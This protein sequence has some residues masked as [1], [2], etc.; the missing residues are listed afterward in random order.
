MNETSYCFTPLPAFG[1]VSVPNFGHSNRYVV[2]SHCCFSSNFPADTTGRFFHI[3]ICYLYI[4]FGWT[5]AEAEVPILW[6]PNVKNWLIGKDPGAGKLWRQEKGVTEEEMF[7]WHH[8][9]SGHEFSKFRKTMKDW[10]AWCTA[11]HGV[12]KSWT[13]V[14]DWTTNKHNL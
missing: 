1:A 13:Q 8:P 4:F 11:V 6:P 10:E 12:G 9:H 3:L 7:G 5:D 2:A 14:S